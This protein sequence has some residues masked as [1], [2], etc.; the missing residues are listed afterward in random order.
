M[1]TRILCTALLLVTATALAD[2]AP[3]EKPKFVGDWAWSWKDADGTMQRRVLKITEGAKKKLVAEEL[4][5]D[6]ESPV[7]V[8]NLVVDGKAISFDVTR[9]KKLA[10][11]KGTYKGKNAIDGLVYVT[12]EG[13]ANEFAWTAK[14]VAK[15]AQ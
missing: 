14:R 3:E 10:R 8:D 5:N 4:M 12:V 1:S 7:K 15:D 11:Y 9:D 2:D 6:D 13:Q